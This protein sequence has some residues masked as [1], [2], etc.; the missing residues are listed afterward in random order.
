[1]AQVVER[2]FFIEKNLKTLKSYFPEKPRKYT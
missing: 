1:M 2:G